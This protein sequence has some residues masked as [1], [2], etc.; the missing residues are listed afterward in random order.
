MSRTRATKVDTKISILE[1][2]K[3]V[4]SANDAGFPV[5]GATLYGCLKRKQVAEICD[6]G[7]VEE[8]DSAYMRSKGAGNMFHITDAGRNFISI[9]KD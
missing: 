7:L 2:L 8:C 6:S 5:P 1:T 4:A 9:V 3:M